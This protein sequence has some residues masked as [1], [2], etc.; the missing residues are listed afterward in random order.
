VRVDVATV[1]NSCFKVLGN[2][3]Q[4][5]FGSQLSGLSSFDLQ[6]GTLVCVAPAAA[7]VGPVELTLEW[8]GITLPLTGPK[9]ERIFFNY[10]ADS[11]GSLDSSASRL[12]DSCSQ[13]LQPFVC[14]P[15]CQGAWNGHALLDAC[16]ECRQNQSAEAKF[17]SSLDCQGRCYGEALFNSSLHSCSCSNQADCLVEPLQVET[18]LKLDF[19]QVYQCLVASSVGLLLFVNLVVS[20]TE[21]LQG[22]REPKREQHDYQPAKMSSTA[23]GGQRSPSPEHDQQSREVVGMELD[24]LEEDEKKYTEE[25]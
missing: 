16:N 23:E 24:G 21:F 8:N 5:R 20:G 1:E 3:I 12:C 18:S 6:R 9:G 25:L 13:F 11:S 15:D 10:V 7:D 2:A 22:S 14:R 17:N 19:V 4:C